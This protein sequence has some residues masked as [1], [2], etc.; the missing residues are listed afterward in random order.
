MPKQRSGGGGYLSAQVGGI[1]CV[2]VCF[3]VIYSIFLSADKQQVKPPVQLDTLRAAVAAVAYPTAESDASQ[4]QQAPLAAE[5]PPAPIGTALAPPAAA[6]QETPPSA[7]ATPVGVTAQVRSNLKSL[8]DDCY[9]VFVDAGSNKGVHGRFL[10]EP[11]KYPDNN[12][13]HIYDE[14]FG[15]DR[16]S[17]AF[18]VCVFAFEPN[19]H[20]VP[21]QE[22]IVQAYGKMGWRY[23]FINKGVSDSDGS[24][25]FWPNSCGGRGRNVFEGFSIINRCN[26]PARKSKKIDVIAFAEWLQQHVVQRRLPQGAQARRPR[27]VLKID[28]EGLELPILV[29]LLATGVL[30][31]VDF[32]FLELHRWSSVSHT[33]NGLTMQGE[34]DIT[35]YGTWID[36]LSRFAG[37]SPVVE[38][39][40]EAYMKDGK[41]LPEG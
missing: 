3:G 32:T 11:E 34:N 15:T 31:H 41:P 26:A 35:A 4:R 36:K 10:F 17:S 24:I 8:A 18:P 28:V 40:S 21:S 14:W 20:H 38:W 7:S 19:P 6:V 23:T 29:R 9:H 22:A 2:V 12:V 37:C 5:F 25:T 30:C 13:S 16:R 33:R 27:V 1:L 39:D